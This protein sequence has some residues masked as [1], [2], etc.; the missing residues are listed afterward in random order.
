MQAID[1]S[2]LAPLALRRVAT[3]WTRAQGAHEGDRREHQGADGEA[4]ERDV[5]F[6]RHSTRTFESVKRDHAYYL[7]NAKR[8]C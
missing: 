7:G 4:G 5:D 2:A 3:G 8:R 6:L 1:R